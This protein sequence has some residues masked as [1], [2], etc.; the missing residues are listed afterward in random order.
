[1]EKINVAELLKNCPKGMELDCSLWDGVKL[2]QVREDGRHGYPIVIRTPEH[3]AYLTEKGQYYCEEGSKCIIFPK[4]KTS[5]EGFVPPVEFKDG[6]VVFTTL[7]S[8]AIIKEESGAYYT[9]YCGLNDDDFYLY[10]DVTPMRLATEEEKEKLFQAI[11]DN[12]YKWNAEKKCL[13]KLEKE[14][15]DISSLKPFDKVLV[16]DSDN[17]D[18]TCDLFSH[19]RGKVFYMFCCVS[20]NYRCCIPYEGNEHL[21]GSKDDCDDFYKTWE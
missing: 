2:E 8:I 19:Y 9:V 10:V 17:G 18:W 15:F 13:E 3:L 1:M 7:N 5:W 21:V 12:G 6:D 16:R 14:R 4:G 11:K 20:C